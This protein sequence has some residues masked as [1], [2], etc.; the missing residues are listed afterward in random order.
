MRRRDGAW[1][2]RGLAAAAMLTLTLLILTPIAAVYAEAFAEGPAR[3][4]AA[5]QSAQVRSAAALTLKIALWVVPLNTLFGLTAAWA[6]TRHRF[7]G[8]GLLVALIELP[9]AVSSVVAGLLLVLLYGTRGLLGPSLGALGVQI[10]YATP[11]MVLATTFVTLPFVARALMPLLHARGSSEE[12][13]AISLG[14]SPLQLFWR[15]TLPGVA[16]AL[17]S[18]VLL[19]FARSI[20]EFG[21]VSVV[22]GHVRGRTD[23]LAL[24]IDALYN[25]YN[26]IA[27]F[28]LA[29]LL[30]AVG[31][32][33]VALGGRDHAAGDLSKNKEIR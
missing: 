11:G 12:L 5:L 1:A 19:T 28:A 17:L 29:A 2:A 21:A 31:L 24:T 13:A 22:S 27:A 30:S 6:V 26:F 23:T 8:R 33:G 14:A 16:P 20:G 9:F 7:W 18:G 4:L 25:D 32:L 15:V 3:L 10:I